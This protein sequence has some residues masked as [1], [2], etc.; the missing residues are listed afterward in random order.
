MDLE[1]DAQRSGIINVTVIL[2]RRYYII[3]VYS[4]TAKALMRHFRFRLSRPQQEPRSPSRAET[5]ASVALGAAAKH[6]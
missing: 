1:W 3:V 2:D 6:C 5:A 4:M